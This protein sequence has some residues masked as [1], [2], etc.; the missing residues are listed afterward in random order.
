[1]LWRSDGEKD[2]EAQDRT[3]NRQIFNPALFQKLSRPSQEFVCPGSKICTRQSHVKGALHG[4]RS[5]KERQNKIGYSK[6]L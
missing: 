6:R 5:R 1:M 2:A 3:A 4:L